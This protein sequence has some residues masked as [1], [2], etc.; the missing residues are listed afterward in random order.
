M[1]ARIEIRL[2]ERKTYSNVA[3]PNPIMQIRRLTSFQ[4]LEMERAKNKEKNHQKTVSGT[5][6]GEFTV[7][8]TINSL[9][10]DLIIVN[11]FDTE[12]NTGISPIHHIVF[13]L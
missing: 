10:N 2:I 9:L 11:Y 13:S 3:I 4:Y 5:F 12:S 7:H 1:E 6:I 8:N